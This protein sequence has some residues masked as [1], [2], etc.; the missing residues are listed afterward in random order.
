MTQKTSGLTGLDWVVI[1]CG[2]VALALAVAYMTGFG[3]AKHLRKLG[4]QDAGSGE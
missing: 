3:P 1:V 4:D 2:A